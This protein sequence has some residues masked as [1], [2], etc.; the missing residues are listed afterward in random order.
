MAGTRKRKHALATIETVNTEVSKDAGHKD[1]YV[2]N[3]IG[4]TQHIHQ[5]DAVGAKKRKT[6]HQGPPTPPPTAWPPAPMS[7]TQ[8]SHKRKRDPN[9]V[10]EEPVR[11]ELIKPAGPNIFARF[12]R[13][14]IIISAR[15][16]RVMNALPS[17]TE[18]SSPSKLF[19]RLNLDEKAPAT[20]A[21][22][23][24]QHGLDTPPE[25]PEPEEMELGSQW[26]MALR[27]F[28]Q[29]Y[30]AF[31]R[32]L[33]LYYAH[34][35]TSSPAG[36]RLLLPSITSCFKKRAVTLE[37]IRQLLTVCNASEQNF[38]LEDFG[39]GEVRLRKLEPRGRSMNRAA[40]FIDEASQNE[41]FKSA[42]DQRWTEWRANSL[43]GDAATF[44]GLLALAPIAIN[45]SVEQ[46]AP[47]FSRGQQRLA[48]FKSSQA[49][50]LQLRQSETVPAKPA[51]ERTAGKN[52][53]RGT[54]L[55]E[56][57]VARQHH[58]AS[59][60]AG[61]TKNQLERRSALQRLEEVT[62]IIEL[63][64]AGRP[65]ASFSL[66]AIAS[67][68]QQSLRNPISNEQV[69]LCVRLMSHEICP[70]FI[71]MMPWGDV[72]GVVVTRAGKLTLPDLRARVTAASA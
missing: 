50:A 6:A 11:A 72:V 55:L 35:G 26:P 39:R 28:A 22:S 4:E 7:S 45:T 40:G 1:I 2:F 9:A 60:P 69:E 61:P 59:L 58:V 52:A 20:V 33:G 31:L 13:P 27:D 51:E 63:L 70:G 21:T 38:A 25:T 53:S 23:Q 68:L 62:R 34:N 47:L 43:T 32:A 37:D 3:S 18:C 48:D 46:A 71:Q 24:E 56:R 64:A 29:L 44:I 54:S 16:K 19:G 66:K 8:S 49:A 65:R 14:Q 10:E 17:P 36:V 30:S 12:A 5:E 41:Q 15:N 57:I 67:H 42:L